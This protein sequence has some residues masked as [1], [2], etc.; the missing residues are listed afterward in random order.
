MT[1]LDV[2]KRGQVVVLVD[3]DAGLHIPIFIHSEQGMI[4]GLRLRGE[5]FRRPLTHDLLDAVI[6]RLGAN[7]LRVEIERLG[8]DS[9]GSEVFFASIVLRGPEGTFRVDARS[10]DGVAIALGHNLP[11]YVSEPV[12]AESGI[13]V[14]TPVTTGVPECDRYFARYLRCYDA[15][16]AL[17]DRIAMR[18]TL[19]F[20]G[21][22]I[23]AANVDRARMGAACVRQEAR[24]AA[25]WSQHACWKLDETTT[26]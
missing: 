11:I 25:E 4:I 10:T 21:L 13:R 6:E 23:Q 18:S 16:A 9:T 1:V 7:V 14:D 8:D 26:P 19:H 17:V 20:E 15:K 22:D 24:V 12:R 5:K 3:E 2:D